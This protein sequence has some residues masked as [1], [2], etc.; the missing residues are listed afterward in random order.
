MRMSEA[1]RIIAMVP[2]GYMVSFERVEGHILA[3][4]YFPDKHAGEPLIP[5]EEEAWA[6]A[7]KFAAATKRK[8]V[9][10]Y[11]IGSDFRPVPDYRARMIEN[12]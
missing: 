4:D 5:T 1:M 10:I 8:C 6:L 11:V 12:R 2:R 7:A 9:N 3:S